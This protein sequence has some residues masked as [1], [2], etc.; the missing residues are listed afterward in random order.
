[1]LTAKQQRFVDEYLIDLNATQ[2]AIRAGYSATNA[3]VTGPRLLGNV[4]I[5]EAVA[6]AMK[7]RSERTEVTA[8]MVLRE[9]ARI[10][11][12]DVLE[13]YVLGDDGRVS[14]SEAAP[15]GAT[16]AV[17]SMKRKVR[18]FTRE[19]GSE[20]VSIEVEFKV[21]DK[22]TA[23]HNIGKHLGMFVDRQEITG[24]DGQPLFKSF[25]G[26]DTDAV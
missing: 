26:V 7:A 15:A 6:V 1:M 11:F 3:D 17:S 16:R 8:D 2:A 4:R 25:V 13:H 23:L 9:L 10:G 5:A 12:S 19:D 21:W 18:T 14:L 22:N 24:A 20:E